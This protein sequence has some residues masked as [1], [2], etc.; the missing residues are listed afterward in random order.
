MAV[1]ASL[2]AFVMTLAGGLAAMRIR[3]H[4]HLVLGLA[5][6]LMLG[7]VAFDLIPESLELTRHRPLGVPAPMVGFAAGFVLLHVVE[8]AVAIH[9][10]H[11]DEYAPHVHAHGAGSGGLVAASALVAHSLVDGLS[12]GLGFQSGTDVGVFVALAVVTHDFADGFN[13]FTAASLHRTDR[14]PAVLLLLADAAAPV[15]G[16][17]LGT[18]ASVPDA[19]LGPYLGLFA[20]VLLYL[21]AAEILPEAHSVHPRIMTLCATGLGLLA[22]LCTVGLAG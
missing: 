16:A 12:I 4:R 8:Q 3:D 20:G 18:L 14:R 1:L 10:A 6:G 17:A 5:G 19:V 21:A 13:T 7:V 15:A 2:L 22:V 9:R 11:E